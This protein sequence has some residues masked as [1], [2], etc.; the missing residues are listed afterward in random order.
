MNHPGIFSATLGLMPPWQITSVIFAQDGNRLDITVEYCGEGQTNCL[1]CGS[2]AESHGAVIETWR[3]GDFFHH[4]TFLHARVPRLC[5]PKC[6]GSRVERP[7]SRQGS[8]FHLTE[9]CDFSQ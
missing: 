5:C 4:E 1:S 3:H 9:T 6:G 7:W 8:R 2:V